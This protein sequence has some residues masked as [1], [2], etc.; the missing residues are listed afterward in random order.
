MQLTRSARAA[1]VIPTRVVPSARPSPLTPGQVEREFRRWIDEGARIEVAGAARRDPLSLLSA[2]Y[3]PKHRVALFDTTYALTNV[4]QNEDIRFFV[5]YVAQPGGPRGARVIYPRI[6]YKDI[7]LVWR[8]ASHW[9]RWR[10][11]IWIGKGDVETHV[12]GEEEVVTSDE[13]TTDLPLEVQTALETLMRRVKRVRSDEIAV[14]LVLRRAPPDRVAAYRDF[15]EPRRRARS[16]PRNLVNRGWSIARFTRENDP[17]SLRFVAGFEPDFDAGIVEVSRST[18]RLYG[19]RLRRYRIVSRNRKIQFLFLAAPRLVWI[20]ACQATTTE[21]MSYGVRTIDVP[22]DENLLL[23]GYEYHFVDDEED[24][25]LL[26][27]QIPAGFAG[28]AHPLDDR[29][30]DASRWLDRVPIIR[31]FRSR[32]LGQRSTRRRAARSARRR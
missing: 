20:G 24:P 11:G 22:I 31:E 1:P 32:V 21:I 30:A 2:G 19:G 9:A 15:T 25:P 12:E 23:P 7:S 26:R 17:T 27:S 14:G 5:A 13:A 4:R 8:S 16:D 3:T 6:F 10:D 29:R 18:S 28:E